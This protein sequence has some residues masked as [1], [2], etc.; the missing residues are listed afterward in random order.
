MQLR[1]REVKLLASGHTAKERT[2]GHVNLGL[3]EYRAHVFKAWEALLIKTLILL[4]MSWNGF[5]AMDFVGALPSQE[6]RTT[7]GYPGELRYLQE[8]GSIFCW[9]GQPFKESGRLSAEVSLVVNYP[10]GRKSQAA[11]F[12]K[13][14]M[15]WSLQ[16]CILNTEP[17]IQHTGIAW[18][19]FREGMK[20][21]RGQKAAFMLAMERV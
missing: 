15:V 18:E 14:G 8:E 12:M 19:I 9:H 11:M 13:A 21:E 2:S 4:R 3:F 7:R 20:E 1:H 6:L 5:H 17:S 10:A 16:S